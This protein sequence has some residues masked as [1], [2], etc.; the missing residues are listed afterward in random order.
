MDVFERIDNLLEMLH[1]C[2]YRQ[3]LSMWMPL[4]KRSIWRVVHNEIGNLVVSIEL[5]YRYKIKFKYCDNMRVFQFSCYTSLFKEFSKLFISKA[6][7]E[8]LDSN[9]SIKISVPCSVDIGKTSSTH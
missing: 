9:P 7:L 6:P 8:N 4:C 3:Y 2:I 5:V 1:D